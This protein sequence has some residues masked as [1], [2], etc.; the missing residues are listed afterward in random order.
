MKWLSVPPLLNDPILPLD[1]I[2]HQNPYKS[3]EFR[4]GHIIPHGPISAECSV[5]L[6]STSQHGVL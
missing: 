2:S 1:T 6:I 4:T 5:T 3:V